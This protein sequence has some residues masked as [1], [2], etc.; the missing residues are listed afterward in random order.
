MLPP[1]GTF[2]GDLFVTHLRKTNLVKHNMVC[3]SK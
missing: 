1:P 2:I 3:S